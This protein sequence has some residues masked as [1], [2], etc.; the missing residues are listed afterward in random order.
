MSINAITPS[1]KSMPLFADLEDSQL[2]SFER[3]FRLV[4]F[5]PGDLLMIQGHAA[6]TIFFLESGTVEVL[7]TLPGGGEHAISTLG[8]GSVIGEMALLD[9]IGTRTATVRAVTPARGF[10]IERQD[11]RVLLAQ[12]HSTTFTVQRRITLSL[13]QRLRELL[14]MVSRFP[15]SH[16]QSTPLLPTERE[17]PSGL[18]RDQKLP[19]EYRKILPQLPFFLHFRAEEVEHILAQTTMLT[20][21]RRH[22]LFQEN[23]PGQ[24]SYI[25]VRG[26]VELVCNMDSPYAFSVLGPGRIC[27]HIAL[28]AD[29]PQEATAVTRS[30]TVL[31]ECSRQAFAELCAPQARIAAKFANAI[32][33]NLLI[34]Q[35]KV[36]NHF[37]RLISQAFIRTQRRN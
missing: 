28:I 15:V 7:V 35:A 26:A 19:L 22:A 37:A 10:L 16:E 24:A 11:C 12:T 23:H 29:A 32:L 20:V 30:E 6:D 3:I 31:L 17:S 4:A 5:A 18:V 34:L 36:D 9:E 27:G 21:P 13:C 2:E 1:L 14:A 33:Q 25:I 8:P